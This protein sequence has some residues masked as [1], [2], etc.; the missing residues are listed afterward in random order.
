[1]GYRAVHLQVTG[2][3][4]GQVRIKPPGQLWWELETAAPLMSALHLH[5]EHRES[6]VLRAAWLLSPTPKPLHQRRDLLFLPCSQMSALQLFQGDKWFA[7]VPQ[8]ST[9]AASGFSSC[10]ALAGGGCSLWHGM[11]GGHPQ[12]CIALSLLL[13]LLRYAT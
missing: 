9:G 5:G 6:G 7:A 13:H 10:N 12:P 1:M 11:C 3:S 8:G 4:P 2:S